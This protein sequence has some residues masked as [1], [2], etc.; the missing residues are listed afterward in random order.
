MHRQATICHEVVESVNCLFDQVLNV[1]MFKKKKDVLIYVQTI[2]LFIVTCTKITVKPY[3][4][5]ELWD[6][7]LPLTHSI[8]IDKSVEQMEQNVIRIW[9]ILQ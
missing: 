8:F 7:R 2:L 5:V 9:D 4:A 1:T 6:S 3:S